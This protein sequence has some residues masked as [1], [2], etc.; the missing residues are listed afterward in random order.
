MKIINKCLLVLIIFFICLTL[1][2]G[3]MNNL[4]TVQEENKINNFVNNKYDIPSPVNYKSPTDDFLLVLEIP[5]IKL[6]KG[7]YHY[8]N[9]NN[10]VD[11]NV[12]ILYPKDFKINSSIVLA[13]HSGSS[14][15]AYFNNLDML[16]IN[17]VIFIYYNNQKYNY[18]IR[19]IYEIDKNGKL[20]INTMNNILYLTT[21]GKKDKT[22]QLVIEAT[23]NKKR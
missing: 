18:K 19:K 9:S 3:V 10:N 2:K 22:K 16:K 6:K 8:D 21:C 14:N 11:K 7:I 1:N 23:K 17:D 13:A 5:K 4:S 15:I 20:N 12:T